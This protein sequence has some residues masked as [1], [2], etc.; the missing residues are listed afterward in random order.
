MREFFFSFIIISVCILPQD[1]LAQKVVHLVTAEHEPYIG[2]NLLNKGY[3]HEVVTEAFRRVGYQADIAFYP[4]ARA[5]YLVEKGRR[6][7]LVPMYRNPSLEDTFLFSEPFPGGTL[8]LLKRKSIPIRSFDP[9]DQRQ[10]LRNLQTYTF[11]V[12]R[13]AVTT[14]EF[15][16]A[17][18]LKKDFA[19]SDMQNLLKLSKGRVDF[20]VIDKYTAA[21][22]MVNTLP[23][24]IGEYEFINPPMALTPFYIAFSKNAAHSRQF[25][26]AFNQGLQ[27]MVRD[28]SLEKILSRHGLLQSREASAG[29]TTIRIGTVES[30]YMLLMKQLSQE[31]ERDHP[32]IKL[33]WSVLDENILRLRLMS[34]L[35]ISDGKFDVMMIGSYE[36]PLWAK[37]GWL[38]PIEDFP[39]DYDPDDIVEPVREGLSCDGRMY[40]LPFYAESSMTFYR[41]D[42]FEKAGLTMPRTPSWEDISTFAEALDDP[43]HGIYGIC[44]RGKAGWGANM[45]L[46]NTMVNSFGGRWFDE[47]WN[48]TIDTP[49]WR[50]ALNMYYELLTDYGPP[51][52]ASNNYNDLLS[53]FA[54]GH[55]GIW[56][57]ATIFAGTL[58]HPTMST[59][60]KTVGF[61]AAPRAVTPKGSQWLWTWALGIPTSS[62]FPEAARKFVIWATSKAYIELAAEHEGWV[63]VPSGTRKSTYEN[64]NYQ[65]AAPFADFV[66]DAIRHANPADP[67]LQ[68]VPYTGIQYVSIPEYPAIGTHVGQRIADVLVGDISVTQALK[69]LQRLVSEQMRA[70]GY[71]N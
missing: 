5:T 24:M 45:A 34:D 38:V 14:P 35:A 55:C 41:K 46:L 1:S 58:F 3:I 10:A 6:D 71:T 43:E 11:G 31:F 42:L 19:T 17:T 69:E 50:N 48:T 70:S 63:S 40:A 21:D 56:V 66:Y 18:F 60:S 20:V 64:V 23:H 36:T 57:D 9:L 53:L 13:G 28:R 16:R 2:K 30:T 8:G 47:H 22:I 49:E 68:P 62:R 44:L 7:G 67:T 4:V 37:R 52:P 54:N 61:A 51:L 39:D 32:E 59:V 27:A 15:D 33:E 26:D 29:K 12:V 25:A 65:Q